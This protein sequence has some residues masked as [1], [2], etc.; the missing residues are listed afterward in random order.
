MY[1]YEYS[2]PFSEPASKMDLKLY[3]CGTEDC[4]G[5][6]SWGPALKDHYKIHYIHSGKG[7]FKV[8][9]K[10]YTLSKGDCFLICPN[11]ITYFKSD[12]NDPWTYYWVAFDGINANSYLNR[13]NLS[14]T[15]PVINCENDDLLLNCFQEMFKGSQQ[16][17]SGDLRLLSSLYMLF[18]ILMESTDNNAILENSRLKD[19]YHVTK[20]IKWIEVNYS[21][22]MTI[23]EISDFV[24]L[25]RK[26]FSKLFK[27]SIGMSP[28]NFLIELRFNRACELMKNPYLSIGEISRSVGYADPLLFSRVFKKFKGLPPN[29]YRKSQMQ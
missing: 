16:D 26:Y 17:K 12:E 10:T 21:R 6:N 27:Q 28:Q 18:S 24:G 3:Y 25:N 23:E 19:N 9:D 20:A 5:G 7:I 29:S 11:I 22:N 14:V 1:S 15:H 2:I 4:D 8:G 13:S